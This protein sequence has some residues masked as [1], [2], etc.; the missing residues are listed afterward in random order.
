[1]NDV[2]EA[3]QRAEEWPRWHTRTTGTD[4]SQ[5]FRD[6]RILAAEVKRLREIVAEVER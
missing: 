1:M 6:R 3:I 5:A 4:S 2:D